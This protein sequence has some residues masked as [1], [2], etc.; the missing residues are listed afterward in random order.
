MVE[1]RNV[2]TVITI[3]Q[4]HKIIFRFGILFLPRNMSPGI[5]RFHAT[6]AH[7]ACAALF[8]ISVCV[9]LVQ[10]RCACPS[11]MLNMCQNMFLQHAFCPY[12]FPSCIL[13][14]NMLFK[15]TACYRYWGKI[16]GQNCKCIRFCLMIRF[17]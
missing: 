10:N 7:C 8:R 15:Y 14:D 16:Y 3:G 2:P 12:F 9:I 6:Y 17:K 1:P 4:D 11:S 5:F 13:V